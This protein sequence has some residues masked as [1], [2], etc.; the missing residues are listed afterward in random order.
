MYEKILCISISTALFFMSHSALA[1]DGTINITGT[2]TAGA[3]T[4][5]TPTVTLDSINAEAITAT[6]SDGLTNATPFTIVVNCPDNGQP[7]LGIDFDPTNADTNTGNLEQT[8][9]ATGVEIALFDKNGANTSSPLWVNLNNGT[10]STSITDAVEG[11]NNL[12]YS[13]A[14]ARTGASVAVEPGTIVSALSYTIRY[15]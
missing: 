3:C 6:L 14:L 7:I 9:T 1:V 13:L 2:V 12:N 10:G 5:T 8:G 4:P 11:D 15:N